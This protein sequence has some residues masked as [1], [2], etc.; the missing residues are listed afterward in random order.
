MTLTLEE[1]RACPLCNSTAPFGE[2]DSAPDRLLALLREVAP[3][4]AFAAD[5]LENRRVACPACGF[6]FLSPRLDPSSLVAVYSAWYRHGY[7]EIFD[8]PHHISERERV[9]RRYHLALLSP[10]VSCGGRL[11]D[12]GCGSGVFLNV[13]REAGWRSVVGIEFDETA[14]SFAR[15]SYALEVRQGTIHDSVHGDERFDAITM[16][17]YLEHSGEPGRELD[18]AV[19][20]L[21][22][23]G[24]LAL[25]LPNQGGWLSRL[26]GARWYN[27][28]SNHLGYFDE[29]VLADAL[30]QRGLRIEYMSAPNFETWRDIGVRRLRW[31]R[32]RLRSEPARLSDAFA[33]A[34]TAAPPR[35]RRL[36]SRV[37]RLL[38]DIA[39]E[40][41]D[42]LAGLF[43]Q[44]SN[45]FVV[46]RRI[47]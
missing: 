28:I 27:V 45:L 21:A 14:A 3:E 30:R 15:F 17:D 1:L 23:E 6:V 2:R 37:L 4:L 13:A 19:A 31:L 46:A 20:L 22:D 25:R 35:P 33:P 43:G 42:H 24:V 38:D 9:F 47:G 16:F 29:R 34:A 32:A 12:I 18:R 44:G 5:D 39:V 26:T 36:A 7:R 41:I 8:D 40:Q 11:L 10:H